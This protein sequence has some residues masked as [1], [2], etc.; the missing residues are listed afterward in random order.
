MTIS[1]TQTNKIVFLDSGAF[2]FRSI[3]ACKTDIDLM[4]YCYLNMIVTSLRRLYLEPNDI[5]ILAVDSEKGSWRRDY[6][7]LYKSNRA[8]QRK[9]HKEIVWEEVFKTFGSLL[10]LLDKA[11]NF[12]IV[13][14]DKLEADDII[15]YGVRY[16]KDNEVIIVSNDTDFEMLTVFQNVKLYTPVKQYY[17]KVTNPYS[18]LTSKIQKETTDNL[19][20]PILS[21]KD[22]E[23]RDKIVNLMKL[24]EEIEY[25]IDT[26]FSDLNIDKPFD[27]SL[28]PYK[29]IKHRFMQIYNNPIKPE[30]HKKTRKKYKQNILI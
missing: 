12:H 23:R 7:K 2:M 25:K 18:I 11:T 5:I 30:V 6:D 15:A 26:V 3:Y 29:N 16:F 10:T 27:L 20:T 17:K 1:P 13:K 21:E 24:P 22:Y 19:I 4:K 8:E 14:I 28:L 9:K